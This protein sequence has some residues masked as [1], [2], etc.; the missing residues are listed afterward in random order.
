MLSKICVRDILGVCDDCYYLMM[1]YLYFFLCDFNEDILFY[2]LNFKNEVFKI[3]FVFFFMLE[4]C[5]I[6][7]KDIFFSI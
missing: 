7:V 6:I 4:R 5:S 3:Y 2:F 1:F